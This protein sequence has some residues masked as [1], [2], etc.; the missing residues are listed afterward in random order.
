[1]KHESDMFVP[2]TVLYP[3]IEEVTN[4]SPLGGNSQSTG[5]EKYREVCNTELQDKCAKGIQDHCRKGPLS[6]CHF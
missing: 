6:G 3:G 4:L 5:R 2:S 1:M